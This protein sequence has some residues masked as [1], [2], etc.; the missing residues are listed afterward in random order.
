MQQSRNSCA[1]KNSTCL[2]YSHELY[3]KLSTNQVSESMF[4]FID[5]LGPL[6]V[7]N[8]VKQI[9][10]LYDQNICYIQTD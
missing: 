4:N 7:P 5:T 1:N 8:L 6:L 2:F 9:F 3:L 10:S